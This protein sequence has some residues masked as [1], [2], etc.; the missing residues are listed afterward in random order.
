MNIS[1]FNSI[2]ET[3]S[4]LK[5]RSW[6]KRR[7]KVPGD[8]INFEA[9][10]T[11]KEVVREKM[12]STACKT[13]NFILLL[14]TLLFVGG[15]VFV[16]LQAKTKVDDF[17]NKVDLG[18]KELVLPSLDE[19]RAYAEGSHA[20][21]EARFTA[22]ASAFNKQY[23]SESEKRKRLGYFAASARKVEEH[24]AKIP[25]GSDMF[26]LGLN[27]FADMTDDEFMAMFNFG[28]MQGQQEC[29][30]T[31][32]DRKPL[33]E[34]VRPAELPEAID[35]RQKGIVSPVKNQGRCGSCWT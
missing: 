30:A 11:D 18:T 20:L 1:S 3:R 34:T 19:I 22:W 33:K 17:A 32:K 21:L 27:A 7:T 29:S 26:H 5:A 9:Y 6:R 25:V 24:N 13:I 28:K 35:W 8:S 23:E 15:M 2:Q 10:L 12:A 16:V 4:L 31:N 14:P